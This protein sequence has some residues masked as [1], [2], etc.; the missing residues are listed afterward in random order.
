M[1]SSSPRV[2]WQNGN[3]VDR[4]VQNG[5]SQCL[6]KSASQNNIK[7]KKKE[8]ELNANINK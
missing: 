4:A 5:Q 1:A 8:K 3:E 7:K 6:F 2:N